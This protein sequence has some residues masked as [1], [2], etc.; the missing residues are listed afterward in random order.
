MKIKDDW[1]FEDS[2][3]GL[4]FSVIV[5][6]S[7]DRLQIENIQ[8]DCNNRELWFTK[9]GKFDGTGSRVSECLK[10]EQKTSE[11]DKLANFIMAEVKGEPSV[12]EGAGVTAIRIIK[13]LQAEL[14]K[15]HEAAQAAKAEETED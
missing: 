7:L 12:S 9:E 8:G 10:G 3:T 14:A 6:G 1:K 5:G 4:Q 15:H 13:N 11:I 2:V